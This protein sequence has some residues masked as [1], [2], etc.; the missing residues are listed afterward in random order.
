MPAPDLANATQNVQN[1]PSNF[2]EYDHGKLCN[3]LSVLKF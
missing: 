3:H 2:S 1:A